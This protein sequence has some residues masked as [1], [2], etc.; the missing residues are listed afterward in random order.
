MPAKKF[1]L[2][3]LLTWK[4]IRVKDV[5]ALNLD[6][7]TADGPA[8]WA[9]LD[10]Q[11][12]VWFWCMP[13]VSS[14]LGLEKIVLIATGATNDENHAAVVW[15]PSKVGHDYGQELKTLYKGK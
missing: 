15:P 14:A 9:P 4:T 13:G 1:T 8:L 5:R 2:E 3:Q 12:V 10:D 6:V 11:K 7:R